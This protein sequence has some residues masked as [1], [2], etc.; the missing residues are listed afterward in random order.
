MASERRER[1]RAR[2]RIHTRAR[3]RMCT[4][5]PAGA[6][7][8][9]RCSSIAHQ[10]ARANEHRPARATHGGSEQGGPWRSGQQAEGGWRMADGGWRNAH[11]QPSV[12][13][14]GERHVLRVHA[15]HRVCGVPAPIND[16]LAAA[17]IPRH[18]CSK[19]RNG[20]GSA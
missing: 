3:A 2:A 9:R 11:A 14:A 10:A 4:G 15:V 5:S 19:H 8:Q 12:G 13:Q 6:V 20:G 17:R 7:K 18:A 1:P 16:A